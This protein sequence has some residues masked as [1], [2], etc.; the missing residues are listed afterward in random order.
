MG[1]PGSLLLLSGVYNL[2]FLLYIKADFRSTSGPTTR[3]L[4]NQSLNEAYEGI[5]IGQVLEVNNLFD[6]GLIPG[7]EAF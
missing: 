1:L 4:P 2:G 3:S 7:Y 6:F 5:R